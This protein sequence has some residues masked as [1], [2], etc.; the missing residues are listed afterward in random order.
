MPKSVS[1]AQDYLDID[2]T[3]HIQDMVSDKTSNFG[4]SLSEVDNFYLGYMQ[5]AS[6]DNP[7]STKWPELIV[8]WKSQDNPQECLFLRPDSTDGMDAWVSNYPGDENTNFGDGQVLAAA[9]LPDSAGSYTTRAYFN[10]DLSAFPANKPMTSAYMS[11]YHNPDANPFPMGHQTTSGS[12]STVLRR[13]ISPWTESTITWNN[14][15]STTTGNEV[16]LPQSDTSNQNYMNIDVLPLVSDLLAT[17]NSSFG[18]QMKLLNET[19]GRSMVFAS[20]DHE[21]FFIRPSLKVCFDGPVG[22]VDEVLPPAAKLFVEN[23]VRGESIQLSWELLKKQDLEIS[24]ID[25]QGRVLWKSGMMV[26]SPIGKFEIP[27]KNVSLSPGI[28]LVRM[29]GEEVSASSRVM[30]GF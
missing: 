21:L 30:I 4:F 11:L 29:Q 23:P 6:S 2:L 20:S 14:Q 27:L 28:Y 13:V 7:D 17:P 8:T 1:D 19:P 18:I 10:F 12:N 15:P 24:V 9:A 5:F 25:L 22:T 26:A 16:I 3:M